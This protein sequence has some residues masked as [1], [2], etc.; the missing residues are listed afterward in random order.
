MRR[1]RALKRVGTERWFF[2][3]QDGDG[4]PVAVGPC[5]K[6]CT[7]H[8]SEERAIEHYK[9]SIIPKAEQHA[10]VRA[11]VKCAICGG[12]AH[13]F[14]KIPGTLFESALCQN[15]LTLAD[16]HDSIQLSEY[17][18]RGDQHGAI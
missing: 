14:L 15:H 18:T 16:F 12:L 2:T 1:Y 8:P 6:G 4:S 5:A 13:S 10:I 11:E 9:T 3:V 17:W 7:G